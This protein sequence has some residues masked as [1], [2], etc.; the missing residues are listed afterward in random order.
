MFT[1]ILLPVGSTD[2]D[3]PDFIVLPWGGEIESLFQKRSEAAKAEKKADSNFASLRF[4]IPEAIGFYMPESDDEWLSRLEK[5]HI[6]NGALGVDD[7]A[8]HLLRRWESLRVKMPD[9]PRVSFYDDGSA[10]LSGPL[11]VSAHRW[12][13]SCGITF[14]ECGK[15]KEAYKQR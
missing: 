4:R 5:M 9:P 8:L 1:T 2:I 12:E 7:T 13:T 10:F 11:G 15:V 3:G 14:E 6:E